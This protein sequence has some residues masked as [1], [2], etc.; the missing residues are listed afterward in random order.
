MNI[1]NNQ[2]H[3]EL[4]A[5]ERHKIL[6]EWNNTQTDYPKDKCIHQLFEAQVQR[7]PNAIAV[8][9]E[10][11]QLTYHE[12]NRR[13]NQ[14]AH[15]LHSLGVGPEVIVGICIDR[16]LD[17]VVGLLGILKAGGAYVSLD[18][19]YPKER[20]AF[21]LADAKVTI[22]LTQQKLLT[23]L[24]EHK[25]HL[26]CLDTNDRVISQNRSE[27]LLSG[28]ESGVE[29]EN[30][31]YVI[32]TSGSTG[33]PKG[34]VMRHFS[35]SNLIAWQ[36]KHTTVP[37]A[38]TLQFTPVSFDVSFQEIFSTWCS[39]GTLVLVSEK[40]RRDTVALLNLITEQ[41]VERLFMPFVALQQLSDVV[42]EGLGTIP[43]SLREIITAGEQ[44]QITPTLASFFKKL[45]HCTLHN[46]YGPS[47]SHVVTAFT[48]TGPVSNWPTLPPI[49]RPIANTQ[50]YILDQSLQ[51]VSIGIAGE[52]Y[53][54]GV[55][56]ARGY[57]NRP[58]LTLAKF[59]TNPLIYKEKWGG[60]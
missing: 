57:L 1:H 32:Y 52:L 2:S 23:E 58:K 25:A 29:P 20:L 14:L 47:E 7:T 27:N 42:F 4:S 5:A 17:M 13:A 39:G 33:K 41:A 15:H 3:T 51:P 54:G 22:L 37:T 8:V 60:L 11:Q 38:K 45:P 19:T 35:L 56:L 18:P 9:F 49:G 44:L 16:S 24:P 28:V 12:L 40:V 53:I 48:L 26:V 59:I 6:V 36:L 21:M 50:I 55:N 31:A 10:D 30:V 34:V 46:H 43:F